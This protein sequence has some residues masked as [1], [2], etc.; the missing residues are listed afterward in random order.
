[1][2]HAGPS[3]ANYGHAKPL[4]QEGCGPVGVAGRAYEA[5]GRRSQG[6]DKGLFW[7]PLK[8]LALGR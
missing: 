5:D 8:G 3:H 7:S 4:V 1:M 6:N 2:P